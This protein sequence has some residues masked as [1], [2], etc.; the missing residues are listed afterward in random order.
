MGKTVGN[1]I[2][3]RCIIMLDF[4]IATFLKLCETK[5]YTKTAKILEIT[6]P[7]VTQHI[8]YLQ[9]RYQCKLFSYEGKTLRLTPEGEYLRR[10]A[11]AMS[12]N[13]EK[14]IADLQRM[15]AKR[16][17]Y[18]FGCMKEFGDR[19]VPKIVGRMLAQNEDLELELYSDNAKKLV[20]M[21]QCGQLDFVL[22]DKSFMNV[23]V[24]ATP[25]AS[26]PFSIW[27][28][29]EHAEEL[30]N[31]T[32]RKI[33]R[34]KLLL[35]EE[36]A[37]SRAA[38]EEILEIRRYDLNDFYATMVSNTPSSLTALTA[39]NTGICFNYESVMKDEAERGRI[40][41]VAVSD[42]SAS[43]DLVFLHLKD[44]VNASQFKSFFATFKE[45][46]N[47]R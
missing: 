1:T 31:H 20:E 25:L 46:W 12:Q 41:K 30:K 47:N 16:V 14:I 4:R 8:K 17:T 3:L 7:S 15:S 2:F 9:N 18:R 42:F 39:E 33:F 11:K 29:P 36:G 21:L 44:N 32:F 10:H 26:E 23:D 6:Q 5:S 22:V 45:Q 34:E 35:R 19:L 27:A 24:V 37:G 28:S 43:R 40:A 13:S 38:L